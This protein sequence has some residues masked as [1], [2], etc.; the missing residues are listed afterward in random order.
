MAILIWL[1]KNRIQR[2][3]A[4]CDE[5]VSYLQIDYSR[6]TSIILGSEAQGLTALW[7]NQ[8]A[9]DVE[10]DLLKKTRLPMLGVADSLNV[11]TAAA[12]F[13]YETRRFRSQDSNFC[14]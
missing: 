7:S 2:V 3:T 13:F 9:E 14:Q 4:L 1:R 12:V 8:T 5:S 10:F 11:S 6:P